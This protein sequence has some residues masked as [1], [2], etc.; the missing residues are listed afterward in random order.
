MKAVD[1]FYRKPS[2]A[3]RFNSRFIPVPF[4]GCWIW[5]ANLRKDG[6][7]DIGDGPKKKLAH[8]VSYELHKGSIPDGMVIDHL[9]R[10]P[11]CVNP[12]HLEAVSPRENY[13]RGIGLPTMLERLSKRTHCKNGHEVSVLNTHVNELGQRSCRVCWRTRARFYRKQ[14]REASAKG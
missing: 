4:S 9:C 12:S 14:K 6:Y 5:T 10:V 3:E 2:L 7:A 13:I 11:C 8:R 1:V